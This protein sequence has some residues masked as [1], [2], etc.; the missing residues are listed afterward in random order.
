MDNRTP[1]FPDMR[2][3]RFSVTETSMSV[4]RV[5]GL[6]ADGRSVSRVGHDLP[7][8]IKEIGDDAQNR[9]EGRKAR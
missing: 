6:H 2:G 7:L 3:W 5:E 4:Y 1:T 9:P 8:L